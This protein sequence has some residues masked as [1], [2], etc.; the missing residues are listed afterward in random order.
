M[1]CTSGFMDDAISAFNGQHG[2]MSMPLPRVT[3]LR[4]QAQA[5][6]VS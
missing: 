6:A 5:S 4:R 1:L 2:G 3:S